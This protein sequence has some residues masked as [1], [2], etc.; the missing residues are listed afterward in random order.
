[1]N[2]FTKR[3]RTK[4]IN[5]ENKAQVKISINN[6]ITLKFCMAIVNFKEIERIG[7]ESVIQEGIKHRDDFNDT[8]E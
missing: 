3:P 6:R 2:F 8:V 4:I 1:M 5:K 7:K